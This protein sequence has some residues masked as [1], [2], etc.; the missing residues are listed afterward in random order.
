MLR[1]T[2]AL[3]TIWLLLLAGCAERTATTT[4]S[5]SPRT[6]G[7]S[8][9][10]TTGTTD[11]SVIPA[12]TELV[13]RT[14]EEIRTNNVGASRN[15]SAQMER[16]VVT[17]DGVTLIP[18]GSDV[19]LSV[20]ESSDKQLVLGIRSVRIRGREYFVATGEVEKGNEGIGMNRRTATM[21]GGGA[22]LGT[23]VGAVAGGAK[24]AAIGA[25]VGAGAGAAV[26]VM[27]RGKE[28][29]IPAE[30]VLTFRLDESL[31]LNETP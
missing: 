14:N 16:D 12:G 9:P 15:Y 18:R 28:V 13:I 19:N 11:T 26:Q 1:Q 21:V 31:R 10:V 23:L 8:A 2:I 5:P 27:T 30:S 7:R 3:S 20:F 17:S 6:T 29:N 25:A 24:G 22:L 4:T